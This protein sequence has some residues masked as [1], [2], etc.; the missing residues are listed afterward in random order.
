NSVADVERSGKRRLVIAIGG[1]QGLDE[2]VLARADLRWS[3]SP[4][5]FLHEM[6]RLI[7]LE[8]LYR[9][10]KILRGEPYHR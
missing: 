2:T 1:P 4:L 7:A 3:L 8:Q 5:T 6:A 9:A 10:A